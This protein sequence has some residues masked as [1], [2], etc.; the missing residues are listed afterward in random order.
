MTPSDSQPFLTANSTS[1]LPHST[2]SSLSPAPQHQ[3]RKKYLYFLNLAAGTSYTTFSSFLIA[4]HLTILLFVFLNASQ[5]FLLADFHKIPSSQVGTTAGLLGLA[6]ELIALLMNWVW[7]W[8]SDFSS[9]GLVYSMGFGLMGSGMGLLVGWAGLGLGGLLGARAVFSLGGAAASSML[10]GAIAD[11]AVDEDRGK[12]SGLVGLL[13]G[14]G[15]LVALFVLLP[16]PSRFAII[17]NGIRTTYLAVCALSIAFGLILFIAFRQN[18]PPT[19]TTPA[20]T[21]EKRKGNPFPLLLSSLQTALKNPTLLLGLTSSFLARALSVSLSFLLPL[22]VYKTY[23]SSGLCQPAETPT[24]SSAFGAGEIDR[25]GCRDA[26]VRASI[27]GGVGQVGGLVGAAVVGYLSDKL[28]QTLLPTLASAF[29][30]LPCLLLPILKPTSAVSP[31]LTFLLGLC[32]STFLISHLTLTTNSKALPAHLRGSV[33]GLSS[34]AGAVGVLVISG[35]GGLIVD[36]NFGTWG[37][38]GVWVLVAGLLCVGTVLGVWVWILE[39]RGGA[40]KEGE[41]D[42]TGVVGGAD[43]D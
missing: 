41:G 2:P 29:G 12:T 26:Y 31:F 42:E 35:L 11:F 25:E 28:S 9:R 23:I 40:R 30:I 14:C 33:G 38:G 1:S 15:A 24:S 22:W 19:P 13:S 34:S 43:V 4:A 17:A 10:V 8:V 32:Q 27:L 20:S 16:I 6:D 5:P 3:Q 36:L 21:A 18:K 39:R 7:G 37:S